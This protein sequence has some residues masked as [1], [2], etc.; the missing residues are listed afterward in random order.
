MYLSFKTARIYFTAIESNDYLE[1]QKSLVIRTV[2]GVEYRVDNC[3]GV[4]AKK[5][6]DNLTMA[7][8]TQ[9]YMYIDVDK[10]E[11]TVR[12]IK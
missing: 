3:N 5:M 9:H 8:R 10:C 6:M 7:M 11:S 4:Q 2:S 12:P 1:K